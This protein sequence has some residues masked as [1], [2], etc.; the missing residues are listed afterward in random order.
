MATWQ[1][2]NI[3]REMSP[4]LFNFN[5]L[6]NKK[7]IKKSKNIF[8][9]KIIFKKIIFQ[10]KIFSKKVVPAITDICTGGQQCKYQ[11]LSSGVNISYYFHCGDFF[12]YCSKII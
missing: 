5:F 9:K 6:N 8:S 1:T 12:G 10:K 11:L 7:Y 3:S 2:K 4:F